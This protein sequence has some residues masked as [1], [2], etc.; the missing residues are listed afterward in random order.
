MENPTRFSQIAPHQPLNGIFPLESLLF[1][2]SPFVA[3]E[4]SK[5]P[6]IDK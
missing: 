1:V 3:L 5:D 4:L 2:E 6:L